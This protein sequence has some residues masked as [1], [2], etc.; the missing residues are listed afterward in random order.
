MERMMEKGARRIATNKQARRQFLC[1]PL[2]KI[3]IPKRHDASEDL[4]CFETAL[5]Q[6]TL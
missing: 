5:L 2:L 3:L 1:V 6:G 4:I